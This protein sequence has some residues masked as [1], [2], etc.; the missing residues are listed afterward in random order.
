MDKIRSGYLSPAFSSAHKSAEM[1]HHPCILGD[2]HTKGDKIKGQIRSGCVT[3]AFLGPQ[4]RA[5]MLHHPCIL[6]A[7]KSAQMLRHPCILGD[8]QTKGDKIRGQI[9][10]RCLTPAF[11]GA[12]KRAETLH[13]PCIPGDPKKKWTNSEVATSALPSPGP[14]SR[15]ECYITPA[16][17]G[18][19][20]QRG[21][22]PEVKS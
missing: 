5:E 11:L 7:H 18:I 14:T 6:G 22:K 17:A 13:H 8:P 2:P 19:P 16:F 21:T 4:K 15:Q 3:A 12:Q 20:K 1:L 10:S 9:R